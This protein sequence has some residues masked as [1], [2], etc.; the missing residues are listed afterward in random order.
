MDEKRVSAHR[1][2]TRAGKDKVAETD[3]CPSI[4]LGGGVSGPSG[5]PESPTRKKQKKNLKPKTPKNQNNQKIKKND[6]KENESEKE[7]ENNK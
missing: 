3:K 2:A 6:L 4:S 1:V 7:I 5:E